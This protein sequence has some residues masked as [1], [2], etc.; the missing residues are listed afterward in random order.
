MTTYLQSAARIYFG[1]Y[2]GLTRKN[3]QGIILSFISA[4][5]MDI[6][7]FL[8]L[9]F[10]N[11]L[12]L[13]I[14]TSG[15]IMTCYGM[16]TIFGG[17]F[18]GKLSDRISPN[19]VT[20]ASLLI[21]SIAFMMLIHLKSVELLMLNLFVVGVAS[22]GFIT[23][24]YTW[25]LRHCGSH[26]P[27]KLRAMNILCTASN[28]GFGISSGI[29]TY[30]VSDGFDSMMKIAG[31]VLFL[32]AIYSSFLDRKQTLSLPENKYNSADNLT[33]VAADNG[34]KSIV[35]LMLGCV[36]LMGLIIAQL[37][38]TYSIYINETFPGYGMQG[39]G[40][41]F[42]LNAFMV[43]LLQTPIVDVLSNYNKVMLAGA[44]AFLIGAGML[45][46]NFSYAF[47]FAMLAC[48]V[49][50]FGEMIFFSVAQYIC[51]HNA[52]EK[53]K[54]QGLGIYRMVFASSRIAGPTLGT[55]I[56]QKFGGNMVWYLCGILGILC[57][58]FC[59]FYKKLD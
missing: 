14:A 59:N 33:V 50:T 27:T 34:N 35:W 48:V 43:V 47:V 42:M 9:Y 16:G 54:G 41:L 28:L 4:V 39:I 29:I 18:G 17:Y 36:F 46:L 25:V 37:N 57:L 30:F 15:V 52:G 49:Y 51:Y 44:G 7:F 1:S 55:V 13:D 26:E 56:Y 23:S 58:G 19:I 3:W 22:Y 38:T 31:S 2:S 53:K 6:Y 11:V 21:Q 10:V 5:V 8:P 12:H 20:T 40:I 24:N 45:M 32:L